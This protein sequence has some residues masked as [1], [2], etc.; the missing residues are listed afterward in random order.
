MRILIP[1]FP[2][3]TTLDAIGPYE[4][5]RQL[6]GAEVFF[7]AADLGPVPD[8]ADSLRLSATHRFDDFSSADVLVV[9]GGPGARPLQRD[10]AFL[11]WILRIHATTSWTTSVCTGSLLLGAAGLLRGLDA[12]T[13]FRAVADLEAHGARYTEERVVVRG[14]VIT[15][16]GV[17]SGI[18]MAL[19]LA[20]RLS[21][22]VA[23]Q[24][25]Q[26]MIEYDPRPPFD[27]GSYAK[28]PQ[29]VRDYLPTPGG[30][31]R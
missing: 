18:D 24:A 28:A 10:R 29:E 9:P 6:P 20:E 27:S 11:D 21:G 26:L 25:A 16:A 4:V 19:V 2:G 8:G 17:S 15:A 1:V 23:A 31:G 3:I 7:P 14:R 22:P 13:H 12:T 30:R 5:L